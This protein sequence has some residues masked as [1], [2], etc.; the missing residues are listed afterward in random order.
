MNQPKIG[1]NG[2]IEEY[3]GGKSWRIE[4]RIGNRVYDHYL[5]RTKEKAEAT[6]LAWVR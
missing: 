5:V 3:E 4:L 2:K 1:H 6:L